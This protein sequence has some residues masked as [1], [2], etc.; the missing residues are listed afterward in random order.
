MS[1][2]TRRR[3]GHHPEP[4]STTRRHQAAESDP[5]GTARPASCTG[6][7]DPRQC[8]SQNDVAERRSWE[9]TRQILLALGL[10]AVRPSREDWCSYRLPDVIDGIPK[11]E[12][13]W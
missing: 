1:D 5:N 12:G 9:A 2:E 10:P 3:P 4:P 11:P 8:L 13:M 7:R 6:C